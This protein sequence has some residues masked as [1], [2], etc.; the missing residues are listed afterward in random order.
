M[1]LLEGPEP[2]VRTLLGKIKA[3]S[4]HRGIR[5]LMEEETDKREFHDWSMG[6]TNLD[7]P[8]DAEVEGYSDFLEVPLTSGAVPLDT[9]K[10][11]RFLTT[12]KKS[13]S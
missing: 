11:L 6:F 12:F 7:L 10:A 13:V 4:R 1:Q 5:V 8:T 3:D 9:A 2:A